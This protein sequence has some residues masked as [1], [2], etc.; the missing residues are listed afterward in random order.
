MTTW[1]HNLSR[2][3]F[4]GGAAGF[5]LVS[6]LQSP[7]PESRNRKLVVI[8]ARGGMDGIS[9]TPPIGDANYQAL[10]Q[11]ITVTAPLK[12]DR[13]FGLNPSLVNYQ[14]LMLAG[15]ARFAPAVAIPVRER[16]HFEA[17]DLLENGGGRL[18]AAETGWLNRALDATG[19]ARG[20]GL[21]VGVDMPLVIRG[22]VQV[23]AWNP[24][25]AQTTPNSRITTILQDLYKRDPLL[26]GALASGIA[27]QTQTKGVGNERTRQND[28]RSFGASVAKLMNAPG[29]PNVV[30]LS[31][32]GF[33]THQRQGAN[34]GLLASRLKLLDDFIAGLQENLGPEWNNTMVVVATE[35]GR[36]ARMNGTGG[37][38]H[39]TASTV[40]LAGGAVRRGGII[41]DWPT[42]ADN[43]LF[44]QRDLAPT[45]DVRAIFK[46]VLA[47]HLGVDR[48]ALDTKVFPDS[49][50]VTPVPNLVV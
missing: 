13:D 40:L 39:G 10:R 6:A 29:G 30:S 49:A 41:G 12:L 4:L 50:S 46:G 36:T 1:P 28:L 20:R 5:M 45:L 42:L 11:E 43:R 3:G 25:E 2:R 47:D 26:G 37:T 44:E 14:K 7:L 38:D 8:I 32:Q 27:V 24:D 23:G 35:F 17:Q 33:D 21:A 9:V 18:Y 22:P 19:P 34:T 15:Q 16:S 48:A 31:Q